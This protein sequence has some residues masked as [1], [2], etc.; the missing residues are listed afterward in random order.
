MSLG[1]NALVG[2]RSLRL[3]GVNHRDISIG[4][5]FIA[6]DPELGGFLADLDLSSIFDFS[7]V[8]Q[9]CP[10]L[11][12]KLKKSQTGEHRTVGNLYQR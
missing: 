3:R 4:N 7:F 1:A 10:E 5:V 12:E 11:V 6:E 8:E 2:I 9:H